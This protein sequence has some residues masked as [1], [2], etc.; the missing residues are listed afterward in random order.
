MKYRDQVRELL[1][2]VDVRKDYLMKIAKGETQATQADAIKLIE[3]IGYTSQKIRELVD[4][5]NN[6]GPY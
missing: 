4:L 3:E 2:R 6:E 5:E 1:S